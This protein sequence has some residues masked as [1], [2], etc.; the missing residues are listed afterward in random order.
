MNKIWSGLGYY[1]RAKRLHEAAQLVCREYNGILP[2]DPD[3]LKDKI[4]GIGLYTAGAIASIAYGVRAAVLDGNVARVLSRMRAIYALD[5]AGKNNQ[6]FLWALARELIPAQSPGDWNQAM[7]ELGATLCTPKDPKCTQCPGKDICLA[8]QEIIAKADL[9][10]AKI[11]KGFFRNNADGLETNGYT[12]DSG[13]L[14]LFF[15]IHLFM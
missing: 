4:P 2:S 11:V 12:D 15:F 7:M 3:I 5:P 14:F 1:S 9:N 8:Y 6:E 10:K 13:F